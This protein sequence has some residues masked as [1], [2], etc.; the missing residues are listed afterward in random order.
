[1]FS[2]LVSFL[3]QAPLLTDILSIYQFIKVG[4]PTF[5]FLSLS[6]VFSNLKT[7]LSSFGNAIL[8]MALKLKTRLILALSP[9]LKT[10][11]SLKMVLVIGLLKTPYIFVV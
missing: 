6:P 10:P 7:S 5:N 9:H 2:A 1:M 11:L 8:S 3:F 4:I